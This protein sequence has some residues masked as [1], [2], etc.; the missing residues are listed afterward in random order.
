MAYLKIAFNA[1]N[2]DSAKNVVLTPDH[3]FPNKFEE[4]T[5]YLIDTIISKNIIT[6]NSKV[7]DFGCGMGRISRELINAFD[8]NVVGID[9]SE[10]MRRLSKEYVNNDK[11]SVYEILEFENYFDVCLSIL[12]L[13]HVENPKQEIDRI[14]KSL[15]SGG[16]LVLLNENKRYVPTGVIAH[17][18]IQFAKW[19]DDNFNVFNAVDSIFHR[20]GIVQYV[21][22]MKSI[23]FYRKL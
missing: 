18:D 15:V 11:F 22:S 7:V 4:E 2:L 12:V 13:Q 14:Y 19:E 17:G 20:I 3:N 9:I 6:N 10:D 23:N 8:C 1:D 16:I 21:D 5:K